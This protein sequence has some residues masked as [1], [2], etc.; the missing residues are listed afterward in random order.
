[1]ATTLR[2]IEHGRFDDPWRSPVGVT[3]EP[4]IAESAIIT[5]SRMASWTVVGPRCE[6]IDSDLLD[7]T[8][9]VKDVDVY[10]AE[11]GKFCNIAAGVRINPTNHPM[12]RAT[13]HHF[14]YR[15]RS[16][17]LSDSDD[18]EIFDWR[19]RH[20][21][22]IGPDVWLGHRAI[23]MPGVSI[24]TGAIV[25]SGAVVT[26]DVAPYTIVAGTPAKIIRRRVEPAV[27]AALLRISWWDW[28]REQIA[29]ALPDFRRLDAARF[30]AKYDPAASCVTTR[31]ECSAVS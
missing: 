21:V 28:T 7:Y 27:E 12:W 17:H 19:R 22:V 24:G 23:V 31:P 8:Y 26:K 6:V 4:S 30:A 20:R 29:Q 16:H 13:L 25:G 11:V 10:N 5:A 15:S 2:P 14:T 9:L 3:E 1:M 18:Q